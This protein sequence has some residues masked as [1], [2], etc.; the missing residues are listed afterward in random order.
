M[1]QAKYKSRAWKRK[2]VRRSTG[3]KILFKRDRV[4]RSRC[5]CGRPL[6]GVRTTGTTTQ[7]R[8]TRPFGG[9]L[10]AKCMRRMIIEDARGAQ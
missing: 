7:K 5:I 3:V 6:A 8:T 1:S 2:V 4:S 9:N 10:C